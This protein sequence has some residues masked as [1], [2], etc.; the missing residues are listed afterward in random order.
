MY[1]RAMT[2]TST[3]RHTRQITAH[4]GVSDDV[5]IAWSDLEQAARRAGRVGAHRAQG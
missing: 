3:A 1:T 5:A 2:E 4:D